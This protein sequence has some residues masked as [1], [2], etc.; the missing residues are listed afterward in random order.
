M[1]FAMKMKRSEHLLLTVS[2][3]RL[4]A[5]ILWGI[6][7]ISF[8]WFSTLFFFPSPNAVIKSKPFVKAITPN[9][10]SELFLKL[11]AVSVLRS[12]IGYLHKNYCNVNWCMPADFWCTLQANMES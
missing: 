1:W 2:H 8:Q 5:T 7:A 4:L 10:C 12:V 3:E 11:A 9:I 6:M